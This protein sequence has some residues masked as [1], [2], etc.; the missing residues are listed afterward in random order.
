MHLPSAVFQ[1]K[2]LCQRVAE[3]AILAVDLRDHQRSW[4]AGSIPVSLLGSVL[5][6]GPNARWTST[7]GWGRRPAHRMIPQNRLP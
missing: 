1:R 2:E 7:I 4:L 6:D 5:A 3:A